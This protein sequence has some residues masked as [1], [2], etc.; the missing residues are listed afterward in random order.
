MTVSI[1]KFDLEKIMS[2]L[3]CFHSMTG[4]LNGDFHFIQTKDQ[5]SV[6]S[7][8]A[9]SKM[10]YNHSKIG[11]T[12]SEFVYLPKNDGSHYVGG[13]LMLSNKEV[14]T[15]VGS[16]QSAGD[17]YIDAQLGVDRFHYRWLM[18]YPRSSARF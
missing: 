2:V 17:G 12:L 9:V 1:N 4:S 11:N 14:M 3:P 6:M 18:V 10:T 16:Y 13:R 8:L 7:D 15:M 5:L